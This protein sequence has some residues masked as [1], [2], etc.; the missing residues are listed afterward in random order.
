MSGSP[1]RSIP[2]EQSCAKVGRDELGSGWKVGHSSVALNQSINQ[3][4]ICLLQYAGTLFCFTFL[5][6]FDD[7]IRMY[8]ALIKEDQ[9]DTVS[10]ERGSYYFYTVLIIRCTSDGPYCTEV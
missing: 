7:A 8:E 5:F 1:K 3:W 4:N 2:E 6:R 9:T 10:L